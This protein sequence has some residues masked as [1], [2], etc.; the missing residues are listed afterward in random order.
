M[1]TLRQRMTSNVPSAGDRGVVDQV[2]AAPLDGVG[3]AAARRRRRA[4]STSSQRRRANSGGSLAQ[5]AA[6]E[7]ARPRAPAARSLM[8]LATS[9]T[10]PSRPRAASSIASVSGSSPVGA[11]RA[12]DARPP[13][14][15]D[16]GRPAARRPSSRAA[17]ARG[18]NRSRRRPARRPARPARAR[19]RRRS[20]GSSSSRAA[21]RSRPPAARAA[22]LLGEDGR[23][24]G[25]E[26]QPGALLDEGAQDR[27]HLG[28]H[29]G[30][31][32]AAVSAQAG[33]AQICAPR[34]R[35]RPAAEC[36]S[37]VVSAAGL[38]ERGQRAAPPPCGPRTLGDAMRVEQRR[39]ASGRRR[40]ASAATSSGRELVVRGL[41]RGE[42]RRDPALDVQRQ[43]RDDRLASRRRAQQRRPARAVAAAPGRDGE[44]ADA[45]PLRTLSS[46]IRRRVRA[47]RPGP[48]G[49]RNA[50]DRRRARPAGSPG[51][52][53]ARRRQQRRQRLGRRGDAQPDERGALDVGV[54]IGRA[55]RAQRRE[56][57]RRCAGATAPRSAATRTWPAGSSSRRMIAL[58]RRSR[59]PASPAPGRRSSGPRRRGRSSALQQVRRDAQVAAA[60]AERAHRRRARPLATVPC[61]AASSASSARGSS[62]NGRPWMALS[63]TRSSGSSMRAP[64]TRRAPPSEPKYDRM[65]IAARRDAAGRRARAAASASRS[66]SRLPS[67]WIAAIAAYDT[68]GL[69]SASSG[70]SAADDRG[71]AR[72]APAPRR[73]APARPRPRRSGT[74]RS[75]ARR[76]RA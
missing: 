50:G 12:P 8:S 52:A 47:A 37:S 56:R 6:A 48:P 20:G 61:A 72:S 41:E 2:D 25:L 23:V 1:S 75:R 7:A 18:R 30:G 54:G 58:G 9:S 74:A 66:V 51:R 45:R 31:R 60:L 46:R 4:S 29:R 64:G 42:Q 27:E 17:A 73:P 19:R 39:V 55:R 16:R 26:V 62:M 43:R 69:A 49:V 5:R 53:S 28:G 36:C 21:S 13:A 15:R 24:R 76:S 33:R 38:A 68:R 63:R 71:D 22:T 44:E 67:D 34:G 59:T 57:R 35:D 10:A 14:R 70:N 40:R 32:H 65:R 3:A 11:G